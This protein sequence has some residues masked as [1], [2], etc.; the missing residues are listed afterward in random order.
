MKSPEEWLDIWMGR[1][2]KAFNGSA[3]VAGNDWYMQQ[4]REHLEAIRDEQRDACLE[5]VKEDMRCALIEMAYSEWDVIEAAI[6]N[7]GKEKS[8]DRP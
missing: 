3:I 4:E 6:L 1:I 8:D 5:A 7:A 2:D